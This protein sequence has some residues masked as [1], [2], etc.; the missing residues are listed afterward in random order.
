MNLFERS[1]F[2]PAIPALMPLPRTLQPLREVSAKCSRG[3]RPRRQGEAHVTHHTKRG[4]P[5][6]ALQLHAFC[7]TP[8]H[9]LPGT[10]RNT[11]PQTQTTYT[12]RSHI[13][14]IRLQHHIPSWLFSF[15]KL[16]QN[17]REHFNPQVTAILYSKSMR[18]FLPMLLLFLSQRTVCQQ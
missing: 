9:H 5:S 6:G 14:Y 12:F 16:P 8:P 1:E 13:P 18:S 10:Y 15:S 7:F 3:Y 11:P 4:A 17:L 2:S